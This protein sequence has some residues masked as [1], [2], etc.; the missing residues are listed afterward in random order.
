MTD[1]ISAQ[2]DP[3]K[4][5]LWRG[6]SGRALAIT[7]S[8]ALVVQL[9]LLSSA[10]VTRWSDSLN[11]RLA[12]ALVAAFVQ[13]AAGTKMISEPLQM[14][15]LKVTSVHS[16]VLKKQDF[17]QLVLTDGRIVPINGRIDLR[18][19]G[20][21]SRFY[22]AL[23]TLRRGGQGELQVIGP[24]Q[25]MPGE[26][27]EIVISET[28]LYAELKDVLVSGLVTA[29]IFAA[30]I[31]LALFWVLRRSLVAPV[32][33]L[34]GA[35]IR[36]AEDPEDPANTLTAW[37]RYDEIGTA[38]KQLRDLQLRLRNLLGEKK[39]LADLGAAVARIN[40][41]LR[42]LFATMQLVSDTLERVDDP[43]V[44][45]A[46]PRLVRALERGIALCESTLEYGRTG[47]IETRLSRAPLRPTLEEA[48][49]QFRTGHPKITF[50]IA[51]SEDTQATFDADHM[52]RII[53]NLTRNALAVVPEDG[54]L[55]ID[56][57]QGKETVSVF[58]K[59]NGPGVPKHVQKTLFDAFSKSASR[60][61]SGLGLAISRELARAMGG[62]LSL[63][64]S[65]EDGTRFKLTL[66][67]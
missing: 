8:L 19:A 64:H 3:S 49:D 9:V 16:I 45:R 1:P 61:G 65:G 26:F 37:N 18:T 40:H 50:H 2:K 24:I 21:F 41:D 33:R 7:L 54:A 10:F 25:K 44:Q 4:T 67:V 53:S 13:E 17:R 32:Q 15:L 48:V 56:A 34:T 36:F 39:R 51:V 6:L 31:G 47:D 5:T 43:R 60:G 38:A 14:E 57:T 23:Q 28:E 55:W 35:M 29:F 59:D 52:F 63:D 27:I 58:I 20:F 22:E 42:N 12:A 46:A 66:P 62:D 11:E 30:C